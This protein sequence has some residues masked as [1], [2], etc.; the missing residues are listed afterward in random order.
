MLSIGC[1]LSW[2]VLSI[3]CALSGRLLSV[4]RALSRRLLSVWCALVR[5]LV[6]VLAWLPR[7]RR[8]ILAR[9]WR[10]IALIR[11]I[12]CLAGSLSGSL[13]GLW[14]IREPAGVRGALGVPTRRRGAVALLGGLLAVVRRLR[15]HDAAGNEGERLP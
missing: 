1:A 5:G 14:I 8:L 2:G 9:R 6:L 7:R 3:G 15:T 10:L 13:S 4:W 12:W 11:R